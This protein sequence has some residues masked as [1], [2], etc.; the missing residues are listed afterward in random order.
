M[1]SLYNIANL[2]HSALVLLFVVVTGL[3]L[4]VSA[5]RRIRLRKIKLSW[6]NGGLFGL[7]LIP[8][9]F[10]T[11]V[12]GL[13]GLELAV[14]GSATSL[15][16]LV[17][18]GYLTG[19][20]FWYIGAALSTSVIITDWGLSWRCCGKTETLPWHEV[21]DYLATGEGRQATYIFFRVDD[22]GRKQR[23]ELEVPPSQRSRFRETV[24]A[25][26]DSRFNYYVSR[27][28]GRRQAE[29]RER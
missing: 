16:W 2:V 8:T 15:G 6:G 29:S 23:F 21:T 25:K 7:P 9:V 27:S 17:L 14:D 4:V 22:R 28:I 5:A 12:V 3:L 20:I 11:I 13:I 26:L 24:E 19:G 1:A 10:I 18:L